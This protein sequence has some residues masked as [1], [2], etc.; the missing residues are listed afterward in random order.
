M[1]DPFFDD[2]PDLEVFPLMEFI[3]AVASCCHL[4]RLCNFSN[5]NSNIV[6]YIRPSSSSSMGRSITL[7]ALL[8]KQGDGDEKACI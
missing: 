8:Y 6:Y 5:S 1:L 7:L 2:D 4:R 3:V